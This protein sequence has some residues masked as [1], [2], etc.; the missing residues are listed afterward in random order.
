MLPSYLS[1]KKSCFGFPLCHIKTRFCSKSA[2]IKISRAQSFGFK[3][4]R[5]SRI[6]LLH[7][8]PHTGSTQFYKTY[9]KYLRQLFHYAHLTK[10]ITF[11]IQYFTSRINI[12]KCWRYE[13]AYLSAL[14]SSL[15]RWIRS[16][17]RN[18]FWW[19]VSIVQCACLFSAHSCSSSPHMGCWL[20]GGRGG[21]VVVV[22]ASGPLSCAS[23]MF[24][25]IRVLS[26]CL[27]LSEEVAELEDT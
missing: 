11:Y 21:M 19:Q 26:I 12:V 4:Y 6:N 2:M 10:N 5:T 15:L 14:K 17:W 8:Q 18:R 20:R 27:V 7:S 25:F 24:D 23:H 9:F 22:T 16:S 13:L 1:E 3:I